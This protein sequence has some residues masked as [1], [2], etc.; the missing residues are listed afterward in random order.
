MSTRISFIP[1]TFCAMAQGNPERI[2][3]FLRRSGNC[4]SVHAMGTRADV[5]AMSERFR[6]RYIPQCATH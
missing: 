1:D 5:A 3:I 6:A 2:M 4:K